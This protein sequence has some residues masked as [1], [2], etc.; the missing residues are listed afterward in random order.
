MDSGDMSTSPDAS[1]SK[2]ESKDLTKILNRTLSPIGT[3]E[4]FKRLMPHILSDSPLSAPVYSDAD[5]V[6]TG[7]PVLSLKD[8]LALIDSDLSHISPRDTSSSCGF[9]DSLE[10]KS[11][12]RGRGPD[13]NVLKAL[14]DSPQGSESSEPRLT[15]FV[16]KKVVATEVVSEADNATGRVKKASFTSATVT[17]E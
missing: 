12:N 2:P 6:I 13:R 10:S 11:G 16:S 9:S 7:T 4:M 14:P 1:V 15:F 17:K 5:S 3:P 8:A